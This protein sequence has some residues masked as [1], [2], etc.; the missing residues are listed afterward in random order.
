MMCTATSLSADGDDDMRRQ[1]Q[2]LQLQNKALQE[3]LRKQ[4]DLIDSLSR[5]V[6]DIQEADRRRNQEL[7]QLHAD[8]KTTSEPEVKSSSFSLGKVSLGGEGGLGFFKSG[9]QGMYPKG[10]FLVDEAR[11]FVEAPVWGEVYFFG[12]V[13]LMTREAENF[14]V[15]LGELYLDFES[16]SRLWDQPGM[17]NIRAGRMYTPFGE[18]YLSRYA[19][20]N[21]LISHSL[22]D[23]WG[24][25]EGLELYGKIGKFSYAFAVQNG[26]SALQDFTSDKSL[27]ARLS[28]DPTPWLHTSVSAMR[29]G[30]LARGDLWSEIWFAGGWFVPFGST[31]VSSFHANLV[32][33]DVSV[34]LPHGHLKA[35]GGYVRY[36]DNDRPSSNQR[37]VYYYS[38]EGVHDIAGKL[39]GAVR[40]SQA[41]AENGFPMV[42]N[43]NMYTYAFSPLTDE[44]WR[45][46][47]GLGY[48]WS[49]N[50]A[51]KGEYSFERGTQINGI[52]RDQED[53][54][55]VEAVFRF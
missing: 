17:V 23:I 5:K 24:V 14:S 52:K 40:F 26:G 19:I 7:E 45:L 54:F 22:S 49:K 27:A 21:P 47:L 11:L 25:D 43:G 37:D 48:R 38:V 34:Q 44:L 32:E 30:D 42:G 33:G 1:L 31:N 12:E 35:F 2:E 55:G 13:N 29:T 9:K 18:E 6:G 8:V 41:F 4:Q 20:D 53:F 16:V 50:L 3:Q 10:D 15:Q 51:L 39:Y 36:D 28:Y 46:S